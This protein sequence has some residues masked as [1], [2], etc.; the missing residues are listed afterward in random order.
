M[1]SPNVGTQIPIVGWEKRYMTPRECAKLQSMTELK[2]LP[3][4][5]EAA[6]AAL[7]NAVNARVVRRVAENLIGKSSTSTQKAKL[8]PQPKKRAA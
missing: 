8:R 3:K 2:H 7:G 5:D 6:Y 1:V 4:S